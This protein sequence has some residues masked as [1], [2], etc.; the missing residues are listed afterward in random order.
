MDSKYSDYEQISLK[1]A[2]SVVIL[3]KNNIKFYM[4]KKFKYEE[5]YLNELRILTLLK[6][7][8][9]RQVPQLVDHYKLNLAQHSE[10]CGVIIYEYINGCDLFDFTDRT[11]PEYQLNNI[12]MQMINLLRKIHALGIIHRDIKLENFVIDNNN[13]VHLID[14]GLSCLTND[15]Y[16][17]TSIIP[18]S[19]HYIS[20]EYVSLHVN[21]NRGY[22]VGQ[23]IIN[24]ILTSN[25][26]FGLSIALYVLYNGDYPYKDN[27]R[28]DTTDFRTITNALNDENYIEVFTLGKKISNENIL[29]IIDLSLETD[30]VSRI[31]TWNSLTSNLE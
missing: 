18:G 13:V 14:F 19:A 28:F 3:V 7:C 4:M 21:L 23:S 20:R 2:D 12:A 24:Q 6:E 31:A 5:L 26:I 11:I 10:Y 22:R 1:D 17:R 15:K 25:D 27:T 8:R 29:G 30:Y 16:V 9:V